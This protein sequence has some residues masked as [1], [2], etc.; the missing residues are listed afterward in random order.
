MEPKFLRGR[1]R[2]CS[3]P[4]SCFAVRCSRCGGPN[5]P[6]PVATI[7]ALAGGLVIAGA[8]AM[9]ASGLHPRSPAQTAEAG[10]GSSPPP[11][12]ASDDKA[13]YGWLEKVMASCDEQA[14]QNSDALHFL[15]V[16]VAP[17]GSSIQG[18]SPD[19]IAEVGS[20][21]KLLSSSDAL[22]GLRNHALTIYQKPLIF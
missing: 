13:E 6:N 21:A 4:V 2:T 8:I 9:A 18:W 15:V 16:P 17:T 20:S 3:S 7:A 12:A 11:A 10:A 14:K 19:P 5:Q 22:T 1:C